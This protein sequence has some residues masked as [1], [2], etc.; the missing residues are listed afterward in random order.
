MGQYGI[1]MMG[2]VVR[3]L[4]DSNSQRSLNDSALIEAL[5]KFAAGSYGV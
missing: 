2:S 4:L 3:S 5:G 1:S